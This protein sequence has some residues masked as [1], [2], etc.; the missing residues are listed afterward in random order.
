MSIKKNSSFNEKNNTS[1]NI[2]TNSNATTIA[3]STITNNQSLGHQRSSSLATKTIVDSIINKTNSTSQNQ[4]N[5]FT[6]GSNS[7]FLNNTPILSNENTTNNFNS[8]FV[9]SYP[10]PSINTIDQNI[11]NL[12]NNSIFNR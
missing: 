11:F 8:K 1:N 6:I 12:N 9:P 10:Y 5:S 7:I 4:N 3:S 2:S